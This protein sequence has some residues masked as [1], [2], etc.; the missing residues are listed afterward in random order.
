MIQAKKKETE[1]DLPPNNKTVLFETMPVGKALLT[2]AIP[3]IVSQLITMIYNLADTFFIGRTNDPYKVAAASVVSI[4]FFILTSLANLF[5][6][7][8]GSLMSRLL[9][10]KREMDAKRVGVFSIYGSLGIAIVYATICFLFTEPLARLLGASDHTI[11]YASSYLFWVVVVGGI[12]STLGMTMSFLLRSAGYSKES[13]IGLAIGGI[14]NIILDPLFM[15]VILPAGNEV[16]GAA[17][18]TMLSNVISLL[19]FLFVYCRLRRKTVFSLSPKYIRIEKK[20]I[21]G[22]LSIG[23]PS[24]L[25]G[26]LANISHIIRNNLTSDYGDIELA[27]YGIIQ[28]ADM[29]PLNIGMGLCQGMMPL[30]A[31]NYASGNYP[32]MKSFTKAAQISGMVIA[33]ICIVVFELFAPGI[34]WLFI[35]DEATIAYGKNFLRIACLATPFM[36]ANFQ[37]IYCLQAM[38]KGKE[39]LI[40]GIFRQGLF[41]IPMIFIMNHLF[42]LYGIVSAQLISDG[43][44]FIF[45][46]LIYHR[47]YGK[48]QQEMK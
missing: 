10:E 35:K 15:F 30:V 31:Y 1:A 32:R 16:T 24:A 48:L 21:V 36:I 8:G 27:A 7:G 25:T 11:G 23:L 38:G 2:M 14:T 44:T 19:Y 3:T 33:S 34:I 29:L 6:V 4:L 17:M 41:A 37:K 28:K 26:M 20:L 46:T 12:P 5:G 9:G 40:L 18:A 22:I 45:S 13:G 47:V 42:Q 39:S 43:I